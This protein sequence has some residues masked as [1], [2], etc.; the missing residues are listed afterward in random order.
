[1]RDYLRTYPGREAV[2]L[3]SLPGGAEAYRYRIRA[4][5]T[6]ELSAEEIHAIG[7]E[8]LARLRTEMEAI[9]KTP[10]LKEF[11]SRLKSDPANFY[12]DREELRADA[13]RL[14][15][16]ARAGLPKQFGRHPKQD[17]V[18]KPIEE[19][20]EKDS[21]AAFYYPPPEDRSRPG[22]YY[23]N[24]YNPT[25]RPRYNLPALTVHEA[26]PGHHMQIAIALE[27]EG[28]PHVRRHGHFTA[29]VEGWGLYSE[30]L[31][32]EMGLYDDDLSRFGMLTYQAWRAC[33]LVVDTGL[34][35]LGWS[36]ERAIEFFRE[37]LALSETEIV[38]E[39]DRYIIWPG[40]A[41]AYMIG[42]REIQKLREEARSRLGSR[43]DIRAF[44]DEVLRHGAVPLSTLR[45]L[46]EAWGRP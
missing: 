39:I 8:E 5:T 36:R 9:A 33:R 15:E 12:R 31:G 29:Y 34:H 3:S 19:Y 46:I 41:L 11:I 20:R 45:K 30:L 26:V 6:T 10:D 7:L 40:Q 42:R 21:V 28:L 38:N 13:Q 14:F 32:V 35:A 25:A 44:H 27:L 22:I 18:V 1:M 37:N 16:K 17:C 23:I 24:T 43:F 2:G 4:H